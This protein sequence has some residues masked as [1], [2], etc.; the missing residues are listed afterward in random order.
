MRL[1]EQVDLLSQ[2]IDQLLEV[3]LQQ[4]QKIEYLTK[5]NKQLKQI[6]LTQQQKDVVDNTLDKKK[7]NDYIG[8]IDQCIHQ[9]N[10]IKKIHNEGAFNKN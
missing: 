1:E 8:T 4:K 10:Q 7:I 9:I 3:C 6:I 5:K 2:N